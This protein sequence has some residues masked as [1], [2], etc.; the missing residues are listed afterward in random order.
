M[1]SLRVDNLKCEITQQLEKLR[2]DCRR[3]IQRGQPPLELRHHPQQNGLCTAAAATASGRGIG[4]CQRRRRGG[5][6]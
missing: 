1:P 5:D 6:G 2:S 4:C 3:L